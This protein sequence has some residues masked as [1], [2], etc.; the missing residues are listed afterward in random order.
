MGIFELIN[1]AREQFAGITL[2]TVWMV[3][4]THTDLEA[5]ARSGVNRVF[6]RFGF[7]ERAGLVSDYDVSNFSELSTIIC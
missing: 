5:G 2:Q 6:C 3:G 1:L 4:D 7:G